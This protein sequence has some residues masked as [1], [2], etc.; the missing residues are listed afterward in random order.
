MSSSL[1]E[2]KK[3]GRYEIRAKIGEGGMG[4]V[5][6]AR[7]EQINRDV[8]IKVLPPALSADA[9]R[10]RRF[11]QEAQAAGSL[12]HPNILVVYDVGTHNGASYVVSELLE[13]ETLR[14][15]ILGWYDRAGK[16]LGPVGSPGLSSEPWQSP[17]G[18]RVV[19]GR[20]D[21]QA[22]D[23]WLLDLTRDTTTSFTF[24]AAVDVCPVWSSDGDRIVFASNRSFHPTAA[25]SHTSRTSRGVRKF[26]CRP[27]R[28]LAASG[29]SP[30]EAA[31]NPNGGVTAGSFSTWRPTKL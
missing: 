7:D 13:G 10:L 5:Y 29:K 23:I 18:K 17:D 6:T 27:F 1:P 8:A 12:N 16:S 21:G 14:D 30:T 3:I 9:D 28:L 25:L 24:D 22:S 20:A 31:T 4:E 2:G 15:R 19:F 11:E 26:T